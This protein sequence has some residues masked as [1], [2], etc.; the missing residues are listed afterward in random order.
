[1]V[2]LSTCAHPPAGA[3]PPTSASRVLGS[4]VPGFRRHT[5]QGRT[6]DTADAAGHVLVVDFFAAYCRPCQRALPEVER[7]HRERPDVAFV[8][9]SLDEDEGTAR[10][11]V[12]RH[13][14]TFPVV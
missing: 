7:I 12:L 4:A 5:L 3:P 1:M 14:L 2:M 13:R 6:F 11:Q 8:G 10:R 9:I